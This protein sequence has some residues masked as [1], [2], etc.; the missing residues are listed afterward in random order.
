MCDLITITDE[1]VYDYKGDYIWIF[2]VKGLVYMLNNVHFAAL[3]V[4][5]V[6]LLLSFPV[7]AVS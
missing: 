5:D 2:S 6:C 4:F 3:H 7:K 1:N